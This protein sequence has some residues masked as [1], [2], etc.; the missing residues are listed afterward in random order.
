[1]EEKNIRPSNMYE[2]IGEH[3]EERSQCR[4]VS[5]SISLNE[6]IFFVFREDMPRECN[7]RR[8]ITKILNY[9]SVNFTSEKTYI[10]AYT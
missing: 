10:C 4:C 9:T 7:G 2:D 1:M 5:I 3:S 6:T 8:E